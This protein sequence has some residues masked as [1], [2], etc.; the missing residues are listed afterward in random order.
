MLQTLERMRHD[1][2]EDSREAVEEHEVV[3]STADGV[4]RPSRTR[5]EPIS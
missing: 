4:E 5:R 1:V 3:V 2:L